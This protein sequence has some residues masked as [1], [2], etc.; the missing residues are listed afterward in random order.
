LK[1]RGIAMLDSGARAAI[2][3]HFDATQA[4]SAVV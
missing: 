1:R 3:S 4:S 2:V